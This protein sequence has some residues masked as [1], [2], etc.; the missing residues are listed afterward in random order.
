MTD[1]LA[2]MGG[3]RGALINICK[4]ASLKRGQLCFGVFEPTIA[5]VSIA[6]ESVASV[7]AARVTPNRLMTVLLAQ[8]VSSHA[9]RDV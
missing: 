7:A 5:C 1:L 6:V 2:I 4:V 8:H 9:F 3:I